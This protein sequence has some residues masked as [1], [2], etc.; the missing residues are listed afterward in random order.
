MKYKKYLVVLLISIF[1]VI[2]LNKISAA[3]PN[4]FPM[5]ENGTVHENSAIGTSVSSDDEL[6]FSYKIIVRTFF[7]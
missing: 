5:A 3:A 2:A 7:K 1:S 6:Y 4:S